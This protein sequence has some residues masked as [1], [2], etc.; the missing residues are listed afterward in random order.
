MGGGVERDYNP[1]LQ[2]CSKHSPLPPSLPAHLL[3]VERLLLSELL[4]ARARRALLSPEREAEAE[5]ERSRPLRDL[6]LD[7]DLPERL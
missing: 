4:R 6:L 2:T 1:H 5:A 7:L 3:P